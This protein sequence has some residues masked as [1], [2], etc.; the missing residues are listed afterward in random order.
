M[1]IVL[2]TFELA[3]QCDQLLIMFSCRF[4]KGLVLLVEAPFYLLFQFRERFKHVSPKA[5]AVAVIMVVLYNR[6]AVFL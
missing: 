1:D 2:Q 4:G 6:L 5:I 3:I